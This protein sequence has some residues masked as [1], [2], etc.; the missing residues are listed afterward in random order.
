MGLFDFISKS[1]AKPAPTSSLGSG[2][3]QNS[4]V[5]NPV[6][7]NQQSQPIYGQVYPSTSLQPQPEQIPS[8]Y[9]AG[10]VQAQDYAPV[11]PQ[12]VQNVQET[13]VQDVDKLDIMNGV[14][15]DPNA[16]QVPPQ[17]QPVSNAVTSDLGEGMKET[18][19]AGSFNTLEPSVQQPAPQQAPSDRDYMQ[20]E[21]AF[22]PGSMIQFQNDQPQPPIP[23]F[24]Q[25]LPEIPVVQG[26]QSGLPNVSQNDTVYQSIFSDNNQPKALTPDSQNPQDQTVPQVNVDTNA[27]AGVHTVASLNASPLDNT[28]D[29]N[30]A[31]VVGSSVMQAAQPEKQANESAALPNPLVQDLSTTQ[32]IVAGDSPTPSDL[33]GV[34][35]MPV[36]PEVQTGN[37][38]MQQTVSPL[39]NKDK[40]DSL[41]IPASITPEVK[42]ERLR[43]SEV[44][45]PG[46]PTEP[47]NSDLPVIPGVLEPVTKSQVEEPSSDQVKPQEVYNQKPIESFKNFSFIGL[48]AAQINNELGNKVSSLVGSLAASNVN[49]IIDST[50]GYGKN[51]V[52]ALMKSES[53]L[54]AVFLNPYYS[55][56]TDESEDVIDVKNYV[57]VVFSNY[58][59]R[60]KHIIKNSDIYI[61]PETDGIQN[62]SEFLLIWSIDFLYTGQHKP[63]ILIGKKWPEIISGLK[64]TLKF[65]DEQVELLNVC[66]DTQ[67]AMSKIT[68]LDDEYK[69]KKTSTVKRILDMREEND[70]VD[71]FMSK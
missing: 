52:S 57:S 70:E 17:P 16:M 12:S 71:Y 69:N 39:I 28:F 13:S 59:D 43:G 22:D 44:V 10:N 1:P 29:P 15:S 21:P 63:I 23:P 47:A 55:S 27:P 38:L 54:T 6:P 7:T 37:S 35:S 3:G 56:Y 61:F 4:T 40:T 24:N 60:I 11:S 14:G 26:S 46:K 9:N 58:I 64:T 18:S 66:K 65:T 2:T 53:K 34:S 20:N 68:Q 45:I 33:S 50:K 8:N 19:Y 31:D 5:Q 25:A 30:S 67:E 36:Y 32:P 62:F 49:F 51:V 42:T 41:N 48:N